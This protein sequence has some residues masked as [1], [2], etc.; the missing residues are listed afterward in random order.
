MYIKDDKSFIIFTISL[1]LYNFY[2]QKQKSS[3]VEL[4]L[5]LNYDN[6]I[7]SSR[8]MRFLQFYIG[9]LFHLYGVESRLEYYLYRNPKVEKR[10]PPLSFGI[11]LCL[12]RLKKEKENENF[13]TI[14]RLHSFIG[15]R[16]DQ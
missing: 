8:Q 1:S 10:C 3:L 5:L 4:S 11:Q 9:N 14:N 13:A 2:C 7:M 12:T 16:Y 6:I 15:H